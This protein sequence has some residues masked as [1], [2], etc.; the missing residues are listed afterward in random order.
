MKSCGPKDPQGRK[1]LKPRKGQDAVKVPF[2]DAGKGTFAFKK[3]GIFSPA[4]KI[5][6]NLRPLASAPSPNPVLRII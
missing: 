4:N 5:L 6:K 1:K 3:Q 2:P